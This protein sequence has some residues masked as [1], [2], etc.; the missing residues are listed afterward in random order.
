VTA[1][2]L[3]LGPNLLDNLEGLFAEVARLRARVE[4]LERS[5]DPEVAEDPNA[6]HPGFLNFRA[7]ARAFD[8]RRKG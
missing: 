8:E 5:A 1:P 4:A 3:K 2:D 7:K 6:P